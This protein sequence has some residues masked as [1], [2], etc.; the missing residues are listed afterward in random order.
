MVVLRDIDF[1]S[2]CEHHMLPFTGKAHIG[3]LPVDGRVVGVSKLARLVERASRRLTIQERLTQSIADALVEALR[4]D[5]VGVVLE[6]IHSCVSLRG[7]SSKGAIMVTSEMRGAFRDD[8]PARSEFLYLMG[9][10]I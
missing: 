8:G 9:S 10:K 7:V 6:S 3:Y 2:L 5:G 1:T 4:P